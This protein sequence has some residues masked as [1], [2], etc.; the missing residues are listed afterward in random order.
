MGAADAGGPHCPCRYSHNREIHPSHADFSALFAPERRTYGTL[1]L[2]RARRRI[3]IDGSRVQ[4]SL[5]RGHLVPGTTRSSSSTS[6]WR[7]RSHVRER[8]LVSQSAILGF[9]LTR[10]ICTLARFR[11]TMLLFKSNICILFCPRILIFNF[12]LGFSNLFQR[13][14]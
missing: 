5:V 13:I 9:H 3:L 4:R 8:R 11:M 1:K 6:R 10:S 12:S 2:M 7:A 14:T